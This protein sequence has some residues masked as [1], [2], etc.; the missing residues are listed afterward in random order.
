MEQKL[1]NYILNLKH[2]FIRIIVYKC[3]RM[4][5]LRVTSPRLFL[6][7]VVASESYDFHMSHVLVQVDLD[8]PWSYVTLRFGS[9]LFLRHIRLLPPEGY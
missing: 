5:K 7:Q 9:G 4:S 6:R 8:Q 2:I 1:D 3:S